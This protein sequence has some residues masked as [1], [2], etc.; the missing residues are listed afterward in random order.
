MEKEASRAGSRGILARLFSSD[1]KVVAL[2]YGLTSLTLLF[3]AF[4]IVLVMRWQLAYPGEPVPG[5]ASLFDSEH[6]FMPEGVMLPGF[7][8]QLAAMHGTLMVFLAVVPLLVGGL[9]NYLVPLMIGAPNLAFPRLSRFGYWCYALGSIIILSTFFIDVGPPTAGWTAYPPLAIVDISGQT[10]W[11]FGLVFVYLSSLILSINI[12]VT[13]V[14]LRAKGMRFMRMPFFVWSQFVTAFLLLLAFPPLAAAAALQLMDRLAGTSF[15]MPSGLVINGE[16]LNVSG[17]GSALLWQHL[18]WFLAHPEVYVLVLPALGIIAEIYANNARKPL[19][20]YRSM[21]MAAVFMGFMS[22]LVWAHH[23][24]LTGMGTGVSTF[25]QATTLIISIPSIIIA[26][27]LVVSL[28]GGSIRFTVPMIFALAFMPM[29]ALG[30]FTGLPLALS[31]TN[32][33]LHDTYYVIGHFHYIVAP[34]T[35][36]AIFAGVYHWFP[37]ITGRRM[38]TWLGHLHFWP[39]F[40]FMNAIFLT[41][42]IQGLGGV[43]RRLYDGGTTYGHGQD[44]AILNVVATHSAIALAVVQLPFILNVFYSLVKGG[45]AGDNPWQ[46][47]TLEWAAS[48]PPLACG[49]WST[50]PKVY[51]APY[52]YSL[53]GE[54]TDYHLQNVPEQSS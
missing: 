25:F 53:P 7:Y 27:S 37:K 51:T 39:S 43:N 24:F 41:M 14:Q 33:Y 46:A 8:N 42:L 50:V 45:R 44:L 4:C 23:M 52:A 22:F 54:S 30:G 49:N 17:G 48:S 35:L 18:F 6:P 29:F 9:G 13:V 47:T 32:I 26:T 36:F 3:L 19:F 5:F 40:L 20:G 34:G 10:F 21:V 12:I 31:A 2:Y 28:W 15:F 16:Q 11:L 1:H 38:S